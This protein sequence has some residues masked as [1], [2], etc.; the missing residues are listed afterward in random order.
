MTLTA[1][2]G[3][4]NAV[5]DSVIPA[6]AK[7]KIKGADYAS[8]DT[9][10]GY[11][12]VRDV[13]L[14]G[15]IAKG[16]KGAPHD[17]R[18]AEL[19]EVVNRAQKLYEKGHFCSSAHKGHNRE[20]ELQD[21]EFLGFVL[22][23]RVGRAV[24]DAVEQ[25]AIFGDVKLKAAAFERAMRGELPFISPE[26]YWP[27]DHIRSIAFLDS[28][29]PHF[30]APLFTVQAPVKDEAAKFE[31]VKLDTAAFQAPAPMDKDVAKC[32]GHCGDYKGR[33]AKM[34]SM[35]GIN[36]GKMAAEAGSGTPY[37]QKKEA[38]KEA[39]AEVKP[40]IMPSAQMSA[41]DDPRVIARFAALEVANAEL[42]KKMKERE[43]A[44]LHKTRVD[45]AMG[46]LKDFILP[47]SLPATL[48]KF[49]GDEEKLAAL[50]S[51]FKKVLPKTPPGTFAAYEAQGVPL[52]DPSLAKF[53]GKDPQTLAKAARFSAD[54]RKLKASP[55]GKGMQTTEEQYIDLCLKN[56]SM[57]YEG[58]L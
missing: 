8:F 5:L 48:A 16:T 40:T 11:I 49:A 23:K 57:I 24:I 14:C 44:D 12:T 50:V 7:I 4:F 2:L 37:E 31:T 15:E 28:K 35:M 20:L 13:V 21:P 27:E 43:D 25:D 1:K 39:P 51:E 33:I 9:G 36:G 53:Q 30:K 45:K 46:D 32:C 26:I 34:E 17:Y 3:T 38:G 55:A 10:D 41:M 56:E 22:P 47:D 19:Q 29:C 6:P 42:T 52:S 58:V 54:Y 18:G